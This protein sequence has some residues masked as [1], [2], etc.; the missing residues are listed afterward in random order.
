MRIP[1]PLPL[2][3]APLKPKRRMPR[4]LANTSWNIFGQIVPLLVGLAVLPLLIR[5]I[6]LDRYGFLTLVW[7]LVGYASIFDF[8]LGRVLV[9]VVAQRVAAGDLQGA[10]HSGRVGLTLMGGFGVVIGA[11]FA[12]GGQWLTTNV[13]KLPAELANEAV[14]AMWLLGASLPFVMLTTGYSGV[15][16]GHQVFRGPNIVRAFLGVASYAGPLLVALWV[17]RLDALVAFTLALRLAAT[18]AHDLL[19]RNACSFGFKPVW[20]DRRTLREL[21]ALGGWI[22]VSNLVSPML[23]YLDRL[24]LGAL[25]PVRMVAFYATP[26]DLIGRAM[27][28][29]GA[30]TSALFPTVAA[31]QP[32]SDAARRLMLQSARLLFVVALPMV[33]AFVALARP[34]LQWWL[35]DEF[36]ANAAPVLQLLAVGVLFNMLAQAPAMLIQGAGKPKHMALL[37]LVELPLFVG[38]LYVLTSRFGIVGTATAAVLRNSGDALVVLMLARRGVASGPLPWRSAISP[39]LVA[40][41]LLLLALWP[42]TL[43]QSVMALLVGLGAFALFAWLVL[44]QEAER[45]RLID[46]IRGTPWSPARSS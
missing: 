37:H 1:P 5:T 28:L 15:L 10:H 25:V 7:V 29:P 13:V 17:T 22:S 24:L 44:L 42:T 30:L 2:P 26:F 43:G 9:R 23:S 4:L 8:G 32:G 20:P 36:A 46:L 27:I 14:H 11:L 31:V 16:T 3:L 39:T 21:F 35:G 6:G 40:V 34:G 45:G 12:V 41:L 19:A 33:F 18:V 38:L